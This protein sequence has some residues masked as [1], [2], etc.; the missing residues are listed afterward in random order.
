MRAGR[1]EPIPSRYVHLDV[2]CAI[3]AE[4][5]AAVCVDALSASF[6]QWL[7]ARGFELIE[8]SVAAVFKLGG[9]AISLGQDRVLSSAGSDELNGALRARGLTV[10]DPDLSMFTLGGGG[11]HCLCQPLRRER[12]GT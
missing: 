2:L 10:H 8:L 6:V 7:R 1:V 12:L 3:V 11:A 9:N 4:R 5:L